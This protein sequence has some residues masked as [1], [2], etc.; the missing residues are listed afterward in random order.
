[1]NQDPTVLTILTAHSSFEFERDPS[2]DRRFAL[3]AQSLGILRMKDLRKGFRH[4][5][6]FRQARV[7]LY[8]LIRVL[9]PSVDSNSDDELRYCIDYG[10]KFGFGF[11]D[12]LGGL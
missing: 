12:F 4:H 6:F 9:K 7:L 1:M 10:P 2:R 5:F 8:C 3:V 11:L